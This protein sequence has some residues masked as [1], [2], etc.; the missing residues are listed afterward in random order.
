MKT[1]L[2]S[3]A[4]G[5]IGAH[6]AQALRARGDRVI[7]IDNLN[8]YYDVRLKR[9]RVKALIPG[10]KMIEADIADRKALGRS[11]PTIK[12][13][14][15]C[16]LA[17]QAGVRYSLTH[18]HAYESANNLGTLNLLEFAK[19]RGIKSFIFS[20]SSSVY[21]ANKKV[22]F[23]VTDPVDHPVSLYAATKRANELTAHVYH[24]LYGMH[25]TGLRFFT[26][27]GPW[28]RP[29][30][31]YFSFTK[32]I[33]EGKP[34][35]VFNYGKMKRDFTYVT[36]IVAGVL[37][38][39]DHNYP[40]EIFNLGN[41]HPVTLGYFISTIE[42]ALG[43][44]AKARMRPLQPGDL[45]ATWADIKKTTRWLHWRPSTDI[46]TGIRRFTDWYKDYFSV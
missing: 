44:K 12:I 39:L 34:I 36:D 23:S 9:D 27:Y 30:M 21:G 10:V 35:E 32:A 16:H 22:P 11:L 42:S 3:G 38:A 14:Q 40:Y 7:G 28:G 5:F 8:P 13:D 24:H 41:S 26:V 4:A 33:L 6:T 45:P 1:I 18:P 46:Q 25:C 17:A 29:D 43:K 31:A 2:V 37:S 20:S 15:I 19:E